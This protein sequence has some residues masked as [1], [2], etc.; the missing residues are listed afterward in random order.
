M[1]RALALAHEAA[2]QGEVPVGAVIIGPDG[3][4]LAEAHNLV[5]TLNDPTA[6]AEMLAVRQ[7]CEALGASRLS[8]CALYVTL[9]PCAMCAGALAAA[10]VARVYF[11]AYDPKSGGVEQGAC[12]FSHPQSHHKPEVYGGLLE[13]EC[14]AVLQ[15]FFRDRREGA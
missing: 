6:H 2:R 8:G 12:V 14:M 10:R 7:A 1:R 9:E 13:L 11:G 5:E 3:T 15:T 4:V